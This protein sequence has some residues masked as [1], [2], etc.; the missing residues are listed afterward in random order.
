MYV[1]HIVRPVGL[2]RSAGAHEYGT[3]TFH[4]ATMPLNYV[5]TS[6]KILFI[7]IPLLFVR[8]T[9]GFWYW[10]NMTPTHSSTSTFS[11]WATNSNAESLQINGSFHV[12]C[13]KWMTAYRLVMVPF[14][15][16]GVIQ[17]VQIC[18][19]HNLLSILQNVRCEVNFVQA[20]INI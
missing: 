17:L 12:I 13:N 15:S 8:F 16:A 1:L 7:S 11:T 5:H 20:S 9:F 10:L 3:V 14:T 18:V 19:T 4:N 6:D 2:G